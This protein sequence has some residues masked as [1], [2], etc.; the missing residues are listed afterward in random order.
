MLVHELQLEYREEQDVQTLDWLDVFAELGRREAAVMLTV[1]EGQDSTQT[2]F[3]RE[4]EEEQVKQ[5]APET[6]E[7]QLLEQEKH[8]SP[9]MNIP[10]VHW[11]A[12]MLLFEESRVRY[13]LSWHRVQ[14]VKERQDKHEGEQD[15]Q[16][17]DEEK[18]REYVDIGQEYRHK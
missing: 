10:V 6:H 5:R 1:P 2:L 18:F 12:Q 16:D 11:L 7:M 17:R 3:K 4:L 9:D 14:F 15:W 13:E 8:C